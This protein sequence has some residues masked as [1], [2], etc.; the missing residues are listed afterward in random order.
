MHN[1]SNCMTVYRGCGIG[2]IT[3]DERLGMINSVDIVNGLLRKY[4]MADVYQSVKLNGHNMSINPM[5][6][7]KATG[8]M[9][10]MKA[11]MENEIHQFLETGEVSLGFKDQELYDRTTKLEEQ[12]TEHACAIFDLH[13][14]VTQISEYYDKFHMIEHLMINL[15]KQSELNK[16]QSAVIVNMTEKIA[17]VE[18]QLSENRDQM[19]AFEHLLTMLVEKKSPVEPSSLVEDDEDKQ[20]EPEMIPV[21][22]SKEEYDDFICVFLPA[23]LVLIVM[24]I[25]TLYHHLRHQFV[26][27][28]NLSPHLLLP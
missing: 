18:K 15:E 4:F 19:L 27:V 13:K 24:L 25:Y 20:Q 7:E 10:K 16:T 28:L 21:P 9:K 17:K 26:G 11:A 22:F 8:Q 2:G 23:S 6:I 14:R 12:H 1:L 5:T 3:E